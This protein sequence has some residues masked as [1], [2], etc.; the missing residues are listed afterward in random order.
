MHMEQ[1]ITSR[2]SRAWTA[3]AAVLALSAT[4]TLAQESVPA[5]PAPQVL[6]QQ[7]QSSPQSSVAPVPA[8]TVAPPAPA[9]LVLPPAESATTP[10]PDATTTAGTS[11]AAAAPSET[12]AR[13]RPESSIVRKAPPQAAAPKPRVPTATAVG[14]AGDG[15]LAE[16]PVP[17]AA[18]QQPAATPANPA[19]AP[20]PPVQA[21]RTDATD[22]TM[23]A[24]AGL[25]VLL[26]LAGAGALALSLR[27]RRR[28][29]DDGE[30]YVTAEPVV[31][32][33]APAPLAQEDPVTPEATTA[34]SAALVGSTGPIPTDPDERKALIE[35]M[36]AAPPDAENPFTTPRGR[37]RRARLLLNQ[38]ESEGART[39]S[40]D[41][42][43]YKPSKRSVDPASQE[44]VDA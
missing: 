34:A 42:R 25:L 5:Q 37:R 21:A 30:D 43:T 4:P 39:E 10:T 31:E 32:E 19:P 23:A 41:W 20:A 29:M 8:T 26:C 9:P 28:R 7:V 36:V 12:G 35:R 14:T 24:G 27:R 1:I 2:S 11:A 33:A 17:A 16:G 15:A 13:A 22:L 6:P 38:R 40:F 18:V 3:V 44:V